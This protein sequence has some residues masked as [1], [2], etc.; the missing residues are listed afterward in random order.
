MVTK[1]VQISISFPSFHSLLEGDTLNFGRFLH[2][3]T[4]SALHHSL[5]VGIELAIFAH[6]DLADNL[7]KRLKCHLASKEVRPDNPEKLT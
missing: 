7:V 6:K 1:S 4:T 2:T 3:S 5:L